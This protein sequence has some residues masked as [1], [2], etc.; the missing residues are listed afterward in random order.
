MLARRSLVTRALAPSLCPRLC[1]QMSRAYA[2]NDP[3]SSISRA[4]AASN[5]PE[6]VT[7]SPS[8]SS[9]FHEL[10]E[11]ALLRHV[12]ANS[13]EG[14]PDSVIAAMDEFWNTYFN[15]KGSA[16]WALRGSALD[17][18][19]NKAAPGLCMELGTYCGYTAVR[20]GRLLP[21]GT[22]LVSLE[23][24]PLFAAI[25]SKVV[26]HAGLR[27]SVSVEIGSVIDRLPSITRKHG[28]GPLSTLLLDHK[29]TEFLPDLRFLE[30]KDF[31]DKQ[32][33]VLC[34]WNLYP[35]S[36]ATEQAPRIGQEFMAYLEKRTDS[37]KG[38]HTMRHML[39]DKEV[40]TVSEWFGS[41]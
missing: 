8:A 21:K 1:P 6:S 33:K 12:I 5:E 4:R 29:V 27:D 19:M 39:G 26:E 17:V 9:S 32:T 2:H 7:I 24:E 35:G 18:A 22:H 41:V 20:I 23:I 10:R 25:A 30:E 38:V 36:D 15:G 3:A 37:K 16:E 14:D 28:N 34:D 11:R 31:I 13:T 40:F